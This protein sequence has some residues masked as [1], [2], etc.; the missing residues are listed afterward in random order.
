MNGIRCQLIVCNYCSIIMFK[1]RIDNYLVW[2]GYTYIRT[3][4]LSI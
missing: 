4:G 3:C 2:A 1:N